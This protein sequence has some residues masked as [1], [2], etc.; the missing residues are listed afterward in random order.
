MSDV[1]SVS[2][3]VSQL[4]AQAASSAAT[5]VTASVNA[6]GTSIDPSTSTVSGGDS[7][8][9][10]SS[11]LASATSSPSSGLG[12]T[13]FLKL[14]MT[15]LENQDPDNPMDD[16]QFISE[17][18]QFQSLESATTM[19][20][21]ITTLNSTIQNSVN[22]QTADAQTL[23]NASSVSLIGKQV[24]MKESDVNWA[25][26]VGSTIPINIHLGN[27]DQ[28]QVQ[29]LDGNGNV[30]KTLE[31]SGKNAQNSTMVSWDGTTD[32]GLQAPA[33]N[34]TVNV[35]GQDT[36]SSL[37]SFVQDTVTGVHFTSS[38]TQLDIG[39]QELSASDILDVTTDPSQAGFSD[40]SPSSAVSLIGKQV[41]LTDQTISFGAQANESHQILVN[42]AP[43]SEVNIGITDSNGNMVE[44]Y[45]AQA[46][47][48]GVATFNWNGAQLDGT[49]ASAGQY[50]VVVDGQENNPSLYPFTSGVVQ[51]VNSINGATYLTVGGQSYNVSDV[52]GVSTASS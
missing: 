3:S 6:D 31:A 11:A 13:D 49:Y 23:S 12:E 27:N 42:A 26:Q 30:V 14:L 51:G 47:A 1:S 41:R 39:G 44:A 2:A 17:M 32:A 25:G 48:T 45:Q 19:S 28:A 4:A 35:V 52:I 22:T 38:G 16:T 29:I 7:T 24:T 5:T 36:D 40:L 20:Q 9:S 46:D 50:Q 15:Q 33:G 34:Y 8:S 10:I 18:A 37:Y 43:N 21:G